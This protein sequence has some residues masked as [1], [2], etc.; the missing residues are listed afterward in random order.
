MFNVSEKIGVNSNRM[1]QCCL[2]NKLSQRVKLKETYLEKNLFEIY[3]MTILLFKFQLSQLKAK[4][5]N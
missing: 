4:T 5:V 1:H 2:V 3:L